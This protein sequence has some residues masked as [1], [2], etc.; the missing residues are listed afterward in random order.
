MDD[1]DPDPQLLIDCTAALDAALELA[2]IGVP[3]FPVVLTFNKALAKYEKKPTISEWRNNASTDERQ[4]RQWF[5]N[6]R[7]LIGVPTGI[8]SGWDVVDVDPRH[9]GDVW[10]KK[11]RH[12]LPA[13]TIHQTM[14]GGTH[15]LF[16]HHPGMRSSAGR[17]APGVDV[18]AEGGF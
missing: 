10:L 9:G 17:I 5:T 13:T 18:R 1:G 12:H 15:L 6:T 2:D 11:N 3:V 4:I 7:L 8:R 14:Q 16:R